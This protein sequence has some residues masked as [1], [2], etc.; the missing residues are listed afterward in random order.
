M[1]CSFSV[2]AEFHVIYCIYCRSLINVQFVVGHCFSACSSVCLPCDCLQNNVQL[3]KTLKLDGAFVVDMQEY[4]S[5]STGWYR[6]T[7]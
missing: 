3:L 7:M 2:T 4:Y 6:D 5:H 1:S